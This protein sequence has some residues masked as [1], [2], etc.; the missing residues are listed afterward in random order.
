MY[1]IE[2]CIIKENVNMKEYTSFKTGGV[3][4]VMVEPGDARA[5][6]RA[7]KFFKSENVTPYILGNGSNLLVSDN[8]VERP[9]IHIGRQMSDVS[10]SGDMLICGAGALLSSVAHSAYKASLTGMEFAHGIPGSVG[11]AVCMNAGAYGGEMKDI[12]DWIDYATDD[13]EVYRMDNDTA[14][15]GYRKSFFSDK[16]YVVTAVGIKLKKGKSEEILA[17]MKLLSEKRRSKQ[18]LEYPSAGSTFKRPEGYFAA[19]LIEEAGLKGESVGGARVS[20]KHSGFIINYDNAT[21]SD[22]LE[23]IDRVR[24]RVYEKAN[25]TLENEVKVWE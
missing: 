4:K 5:V 2:N 16:A 19:A 11:G 1:S 24:E 17:Q 23:L 8:G 22:V 25:V 6:A 7:L 15:F 3:A 12:V 18:P 9:I 21:T 14:A 10:V 20:E 13:G